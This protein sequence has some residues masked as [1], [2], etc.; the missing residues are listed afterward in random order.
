MFVLGLNSGY[1][2]KYNP[3][4]SGVYPSS[5]PNTDTVQCTMYLEDSL[6]LF[7]VFSEWAQYYSI[8]SRIQLSLAFLWASSM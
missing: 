1:T 6:L 8:L 5:R 7:R 4:P 2:V 3:L